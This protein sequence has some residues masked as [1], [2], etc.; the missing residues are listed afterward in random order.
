MMALTMD[1]HGRDALMAQSLG[2]AEK[3]AMK[4][5]WKDY[6]KQKYVGKG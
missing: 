4:N 5:V 2:A 6:D 1:E 3:A